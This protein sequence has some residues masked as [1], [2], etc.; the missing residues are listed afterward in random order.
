MVYI[1]LLF[2]LIA[3]EFF[4]F[5]IADKYSIIYKSN[6]RLSHTSITLRD[7]GIF[8]SIVYANYWLTTILVDPVAINGITR[9]TLRLA[10]GKENIESRSLWKPMHLQPIFCNYPYY[11]SNIAS[12]LFE[13]GL[14][15]PSGCNLTEADCDRIKFVVLK[16]FKK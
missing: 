15:L 16:L 7:G 11:G 12:T 13:N 6:S 14:C 5:K 9:E 10:L 8:F 2:L 4:Y 3:I 1:A